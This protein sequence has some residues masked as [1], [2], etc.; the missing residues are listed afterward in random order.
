M[1]LCGLFGRFGSKARLLRSPRSRFRFRLQI[2]LRAVSGKPRPLLLGLLCLVD[3]GKM[4]IFRRDFLK[5]Q[6]GEA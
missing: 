2:L 6:L 5:L 3:R 4:G 1:V